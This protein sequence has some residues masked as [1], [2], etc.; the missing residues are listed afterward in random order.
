[1]EALLRRVHA[2]EAV[3]ISAIQNYI[4]DH[5][6][7]I[8]G[9]KHEQKNNGGRALINPISLYAYLNKAIRYRIQHT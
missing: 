9:S 8:D 4:I 1:M 2:D 3:V 7:V 6:I 5:L